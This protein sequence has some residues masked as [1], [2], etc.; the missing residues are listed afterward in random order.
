[1]TRSIGSQVRLQTTPNQSN[2]IRPTVVRRPVL[3]SIPAPRP[4]LQPSEQ[5]YM[6]AREVAE[7]EQLRSHLATAIAQHRTADTG[8]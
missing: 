5:P 2:S 4:A 3:S 6:E 1:M 8:W 7:A